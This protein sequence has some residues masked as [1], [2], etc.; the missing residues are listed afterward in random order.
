[1]Y[2]SANK[3]GLA[4]AGVIGLVFFAASCDSSVTME[5]VTAR[6]A[7]EWEQDELDCDD[8]SNWYVRNGFFSPYDYVSSNKKYYESPTFKSNFS[9]RSSSSS[10]SFGG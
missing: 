5:D 4:A 1:M 7:C 9:S 3:L 8:D 6:E 10:F 2:L